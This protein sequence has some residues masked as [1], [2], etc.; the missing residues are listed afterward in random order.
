MKSR[1]STYMAAVTVFAG[2]AIP[3]QA[4]IRY[5]PVNTVIPNN[6]AY[7]IDFNHDGTKDC[8]GRDD[9]H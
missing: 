7:G 8:R 1:L 3:V 5:T 2:L 6:G 9:H 4:S